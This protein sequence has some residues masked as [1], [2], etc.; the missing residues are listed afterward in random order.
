MESKPHVLMAGGGTA[1]HVFPGVAVAAALV[2]EGWSVSWTGRAGEMEEHLVESQGIPF[3][4]LRSRAVVGRGVMG[5]AMAVSTLL[6]SAWAARSLVRRLRVDVVLGTGGY[7]SVPAVLG[8]RLAGRPALLLEPN[9]RAGEANRM[10]SRFAQLAAIAYESAASD[11]RCRTEVTGVP[12]RDS[13]FEIPEP[14]ATTPRILVLGGSQGALAVNLLLPPAFEALARQFPGLEIV[15]QVGRHREA[16][17]KA[18]EGY[19]LSSAA[20]E[21]VPFIDDVDEEMARATLIVSRAGAVTLAEICAA[22]RPAVFLPLSLAGG[23]Q[24]DNAQA[25][26]DAGAS[27][28]LEETASVEETVACLAALLADTERRQRMSA[29]LRSFARRDAA[30]SIAALVKELIPGAAS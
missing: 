18:Y 16:T 12:V 23:H 28:M 19:E 14:R 4:Q 10:L 25:L 30:E 17:A 13:F 27:E 5:K 6:R 7:V 3:H 26:V 2:R 21:I 22:G 8:A 11:F 15:H 1:G 29:L 20:L 24:R 9:A